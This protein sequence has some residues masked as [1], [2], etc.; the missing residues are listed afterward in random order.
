MIMRPHGLMK[1]AFGY[2]DAEFIDNIFD[3]PIQRVGGYYNVVE[4]VYN[5]SRAG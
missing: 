3:T 4:F 2:I 5:T 1:T